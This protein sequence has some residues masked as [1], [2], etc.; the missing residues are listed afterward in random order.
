MNFNMTHVILLIS[1]YIVPIAPYYTI[2]YNS[3]CQ[4]HLRFAT[5][6]YQFTQLESSVF[7]RSQKSIKGFFLLKNVYIYIYIYKT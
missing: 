7:S 2:S 6:Y 5:S 4:S 3:K 1:V